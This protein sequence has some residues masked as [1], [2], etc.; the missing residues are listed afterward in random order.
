[1]NLCIIYKGMSLFNNGWL[2]N[3][4]CRIFNSTRNGKF[5]CALY[6]NKWHFNIHSG[7]CRCVMRS[8]DDGFTK[9]LYECK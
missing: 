1:M 8:K 2:I 9:K 4:S 3:S 5:M 7:Y 6:G